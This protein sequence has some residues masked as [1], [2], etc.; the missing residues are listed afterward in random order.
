MH[1]VKYVNI[2]KKKG[3][4]YGEPSAREFFQGLPV[5]APHSHIALP[6]HPDEQAGTGW[7]IPEIVVWLYAFT[8]EQVRLG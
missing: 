5:K 8:L 1:V 4:S 2:L 7:H 6:F 3:K